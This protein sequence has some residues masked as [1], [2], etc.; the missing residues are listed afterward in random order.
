MIEC[1]VK[2]ALSYEDAKKIAKSVITSNLIKC[3]F[4][5]KDANWGRIMCAVGYAGV[6][7]NPGKIDVFINGIKIVSKGKGLKNKKKV[8]KTLNKKE[9]S[10]LIDIHKGKKEATAYGCDLTIKYVKLNAHYTT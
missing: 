10:V 1:N 5:G 7:I 6:D 4:F 3:M 2:G 8:K 9:A